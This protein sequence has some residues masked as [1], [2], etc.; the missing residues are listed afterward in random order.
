M[1]SWSFLTTPISMRNQLARLRIKLINARLQFQRLSRVVLA[2][3]LP[4]TA[5]LMLRFVHDA[6]SNGT[7]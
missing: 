3:E 5:S 1:Y 4:Y 7:N 2:F 6:I